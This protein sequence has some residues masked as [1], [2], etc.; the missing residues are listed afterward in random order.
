MINNDIQM[1]T[2]NGKWINKVNGKVI[3]VL[4]TIIDGD[5][6]LLKTNEGVKTMEEFSRYYIQVSDDIYNENGMVIESK[7]ASF[8]DISSIIHPSIQPSITTKTNKNI[9][10]IKTNENS[11]IYDD[12][13]AEI[14]EH[15]NLNKQLIEKIFTKIN[16]KPEISLNIKCDNFP[17]NELKMLINL[18]DVGED[19]ICNYFI[20]NIIDKNMIFNLIKNYIK[21]ELK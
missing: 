7:P 3:N 13:S 18:F 15:K 6:M 17:V 5:T 19:E 12:K 16:I 2:P 8:T 11:I 21:D 10:T 9:S 14:T 20:D 1:P 4:D